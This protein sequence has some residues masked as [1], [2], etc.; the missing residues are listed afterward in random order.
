MELNTCPVLVELCRDAGIPVPAH[1]PSKSLERMY[2]L[3]D[4]AVRSMSP[5]ILAYSD[6][7]RESFPEHAATLEALGVITDKATATRAIQA[8]KVVSLALSPHRD[9][10]M[11]PV[12][13][14]AFWLCL[15]AM[16]AEEG[17]APLCAYG[18]S[19]LFDLGDAFGVPRR[20]GLAKLIE[21]IA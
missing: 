21:I 2:S 18:A 14:Q 17:R 20:G 1:N 5:R 8:L 11:N 19:G 15:A 12:C 10:S 3:A 13:K 6:G 16:E 9:G 4:W 7:V